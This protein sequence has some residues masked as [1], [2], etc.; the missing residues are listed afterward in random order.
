MKKVLLF[1]ILSLFI[2]CKNPTSAKK[3]LPDYGR[4]LFEVE[5]TNSAW[6]Y[7]LHGF[8][9]NR[10]GGVFRYDHSDVQWN[11]VNHDSI[12]ADELAEKFSH[13]AQFIK[14]IPSDTLTAKCGFVSSAFQGPLTDPVHPCADVGI[15]S[16]Q[17]FIFDSTRAIYQRVLL[18]QAGD[19]GVINLNA[20][21][22][23][24]YQ[25]LM[26]IDTLYSNPGCKP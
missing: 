12:P 24:L 1:A 9:I 4:I 23:P 22:K 8:F 18:Y 3:I 19:L 26:S 20:S 10:S 2:T 11:P 14:I 13:S 21:A 15:T 6:G 5:Y 16:Y 17:A 25:W 7:R